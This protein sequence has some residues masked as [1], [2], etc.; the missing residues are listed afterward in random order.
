MADHDHHDQQK[1]NNQQGRSPTVSTTARCK[2]DKDCQGQQQQ[3]ALH[4]PQKPLSPSPGKPT[5]T[6]TGRLIQPNNLLK[7][8]TANLQSLSPK[9][10]E[11]IAL[12][13]VEKSDVIAL[14][15]TW[16]D[17]QNKNLLAEV[18]IY[19]YKVFHVNKTNSNR[20]GRW[21]NHVCQKH[22][23]PNG[24]KVISTCTKEIIQVDIIPKN[25]VDLKLTDI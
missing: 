13:Q 16:L 19:G 7:V 14:N 4:T 20:K 15:E 3:R 5:E 11:L 18:A 23:E 12:I 24:T 9:I 1:Y 2:N 25:A 17:T 6:K 8:L 10:D 21:I 22:L